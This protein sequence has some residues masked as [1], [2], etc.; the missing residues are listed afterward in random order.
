MIPQLIEDLLLLPPAVSRGSAGCGYRWILPGCWLL[1]A[2]A[3]AGCL[4]DESKTRLLLM[5]DKTNK[6]G[7]HSLDK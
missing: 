7:S 2:A 3:A 4:A 1:L 5:N 6:S